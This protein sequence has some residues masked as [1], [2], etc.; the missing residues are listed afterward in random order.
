MYFCRKLNN[1]CG[2]LIRRR[3]LAML[4]DKFIKLFGAKRNSVNPFF[5][6]C[7]HS[8]QPYTNHS[9]TTI[10]NRVKS[11]GAGIYRVDLG[12]GA[13]ALT[14]ALLAAANAGGIKL[15]A[16][17]QSP[18]AT[19]AGAYNEALAFSSAYAGKI[20]YYQISNEPDLQ[21]GT[22]GG[23]G[24][25]PSDFD[26]T[27]Y[28][29]T[30]TKLQ[31]LLDGVRAG[32]PSARAIVNFT[33]T[34]YGIV[35]RLFDDGLVFDIIGVDW[36]S[37]MDDITNTVGGLNMPS[38]LKSQFGKPVFI[39]E[40]NRWEG[41][42]GGLETTQRDYINQIVQSMYRN[43]DIS[44]YIAYELLDEPEAGVEFERHMGLMYAPTA[45]KPAFSAYKRAISRCGNR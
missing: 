38:Y 9:A 6:M 42:T 39:T 43:K 45:E 2:Y 13:Y 22:V 19:Y 24:Q 3:R 28:A 40:G 16:I 32:D 31:G 29:A 37:N 14:D 10:I 34:H 44:A 17:L 33:W 1:H 23:N 41:S 11:A 12:T 25:L 21:C 18:D 36:Y 30:K 4:R 5:G 15:L 26:D 20:P 27:L 8:W 35:Q 7:G